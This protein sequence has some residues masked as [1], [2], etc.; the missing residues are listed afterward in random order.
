MR[1]SIL[2]DVTENSL[3]RSWHLSLE[4]LRK[5]QDYKP[6]VRRSL[7]ALQNLWEKVVAEGPIV[8]HDNL[9]QG[10]PHPS[11]YMPNTFGVNP[12]GEGLNV[13]IFDSYNFP[14]LQDMS[15][16]NSVPGNLY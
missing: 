11:L 2:A 10:H 9:S 12:L 8:R 6:S 16:V 4:I 5:Y 13:S 15:W 3:A 7:T 14:D 1:A